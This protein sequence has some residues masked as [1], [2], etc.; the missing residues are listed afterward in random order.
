MAAVLAFRRW[1]AAAVPVLAITF[2]AARSFADALATD[3]IFRVLP[4][5]VGAC[6][7]IEDLSRYTDPTTHLKLIDRIAGL[8]S[9][10]NW[11]N[12]PNYK[13]FEILVASLPAYFGISNADLVNDIFG[14]S[15]VLAFRPP[16]K[17]YPPNGILLCRAAKEE[18]LAKVVERI[19]APT[20]FRKVTEHLHR[21]VAFVERLEFNARHDF[22]VRL[23]PIVAISDKKDAIEKV[24]DVSLD[25]DSLFDSTEF[26]DMRAAIGEGAVA[27][28]L[29]ST[30]TLTPLLEQSITEGGTAGHV[31]SALLADMWQALDWAAI[32]LRIG[33]PV[34]LS[35]FASLDT[36]RLD[37]RH[38]IWPD[39]FAE[40]S[41]YWKSV[42]SDAMAAVATQMDF[43]AL[44]VLLHGIA[45]EVPEIKDVLVAVSGLVE[46]LPKNKLL[47]RLGP[48][49]GAMAVVAP[50]GDLQLTAE[51]AIRAEGAPEMAGLPLPQAIELI[52]LRPM[53]L[54]YSLDYN[55]QFEDSTRVTTRQIGKLRLHSLTGSKWL[56][57]WIEP[58][59][60]VSDERIYF[61]SSPAAIAN[62]LSP[63]SESFP[64]SKAAQ[65][66]Q[67]ALGEDAVLKGYLNVARLRAY[68]AS[69]QKALVSQIAEQIPKEEEDAVSRKIDDVSSILSLIDFVTLSTATEGNVHQWTLAAFPSP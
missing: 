18:T 8:E 62:R 31:V 68:M 6:L 35:A 52:A 4:K 53:L 12:S 14:E 55:R 67:R 20:G 41:E 9:F 16:T 56:P 46:G 3:Q 69:N 17:S 45:D 57:A 26:G 36:S 61:A 38:R 15:V 47:S 50:E 33:D 21:G 10:Q 7:V 22:L 28:L 1:T 11:K 23:G 58:T 59:L 13:S 34:E 60:A 54:F 51:I 42:P 48:Q 43:P 2:L 24:I 37:E 63:P 64:E 40:P 27:Q 44:A 66:I 29:L 49:V 65:R 32:S 25:G 39:L 19:S 30:R 5:D